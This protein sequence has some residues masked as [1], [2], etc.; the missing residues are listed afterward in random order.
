[1]VSCDESS[2]L[3]LRDPEAVP[4]AALMEGI[5]SGGGVEVRDELQ[6][7]E[8]SEV[9]SLQPHEHPYRCQ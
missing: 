7:V 2:A 1:M 6:V 8:A 9:R 3:K 5:G 4:L